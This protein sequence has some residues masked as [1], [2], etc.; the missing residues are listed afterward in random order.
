MPGGENL[1]ERSA[2]QGCGIGF[3]GLPGGISAQF[4]GAGMPANRASSQGIAL[5]SH[6]TAAT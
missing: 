3:S 4:W 2:R 1:G 6:G 5:A